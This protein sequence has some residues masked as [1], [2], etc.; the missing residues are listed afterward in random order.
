M[1]DNLYKKYTESKTRRWDVG[2]GVF[3]GTPVIN[4]QNGEI[5]VTLADSGGTT[6]TETSNL[7]G[8]LTSV[9]RRSAGVGYDSGIAVVARDGSWLFEV[10]GVTDGET[11][12]NG[13]AG[14][15]QG[16]K[17][18]ATVTSGVITGLT[19]AADDGGSPAV[20]NTYVG[21]IDDGYI[22]DGVAPVEIGVAE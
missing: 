21:I 17:V 7:P 18:Y 2:V 15:N 1:A 4:K 22:V 12:P 16:T 13:G 10:T 5:G 8:S 19:L 11:T 9:T 3:G 6:R 14:T 20:D